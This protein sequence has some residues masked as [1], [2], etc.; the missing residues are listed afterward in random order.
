MIPNNPDAPWWATE[1]DYPDPGVVEYIRPVGS[2]MCGDSREELAVCLMQRDS[3]PVQVSL[4]GTRLFAFEADLLCE[5]V[6]SATAV[7]LMVNDAAKPQ[8]VVENLE[9]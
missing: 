8:M 5:V 3:D 7:M 6:R 1:A 4:A 2:V 9:E